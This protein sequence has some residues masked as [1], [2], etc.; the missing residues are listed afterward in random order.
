MPV[1]AR[2]VELVHD[3][4]RVRVLAVEERVEHLAGLRVLPLR[5]SAGEHP[6]R[7]QRAH[8]HEAEA[9]AEELSKLA[10][11]VRLADARLAEEQ[12]R[13]QLDRVVRVDAER[14]VPADVREHH[15][16]VGQLLEQALH[17]GQRRRLDGE[18]LAAQAHHLLVER[19]QR[20]VRRC[21][22]LLQRFLYRGDFIDV[23]ETGDRDGHS[24]GHGVPLLAAFCAEKIAWHSIRSKQRA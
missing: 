4:D 24:G 14:E 18:A 19:A 2:L 15:G 6:A 16:E 22:Q 17:L 20:F 5:R 12:H 23:L 1:R 21:G 13:R 3:D 11:E 10:R 7:S 9:G 8:G